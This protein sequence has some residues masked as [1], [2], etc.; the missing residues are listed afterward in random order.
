M[1][2]PMKI[3]RYVAEVPR[4][5]TDNF[6]DYCLEHPDDNALAVFEKFNK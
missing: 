2:T 1:I 6:M 4:E 3:T 5:A